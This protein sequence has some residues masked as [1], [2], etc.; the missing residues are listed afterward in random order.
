MQ[1]LWEQQWAGLGLGGH[2]TKGLLLL[3]LL[4]LVSPSSDADEGLCRSLARCEPN[5]RPSYTK[6]GAQRL[7]GGLAQVVEQLGAVEPVPSTWWRAGR[8][9]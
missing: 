6:E 1:A 7:A 4:L 3:L 8:F 9:S 2:E 5:R